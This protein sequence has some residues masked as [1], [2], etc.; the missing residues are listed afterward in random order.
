MEDCCATVMI[1]NEQM[2]E[3][4]I[5]KK[6][7]EPHKKIASAKKEISIPSRWGFTGGRSEPGDKGP[8]QTA[9][10][11]TLEELGVRVKIFPALKVVE[12]SKDHLNVLFLGRQEGGVPRPQNE[13]VIA[14][15]WVPIQALQDLYLFKKI[16][17]E[18]EL[19]YVGHRRRALKLLRLLERTK[20]EN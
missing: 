13:E 19:I 2:D 14:V 17:G 3:I 10:R 8:V 11:E 20:K 5:I 1:V 18:E 16:L 7:A 12:E 9:K 15:R 4:L 6:A